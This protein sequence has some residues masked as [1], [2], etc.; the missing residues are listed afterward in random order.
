MKKNSSAAPTAKT[1]PHVKK[2]NSLVAIPAGQVQGRVRVDRIWRCPPQTLYQ[3][4]VGPHQKLH[5]VQSSVLRGQIQG[6][7]TPAVPDSRI[8][9]VLQEQRDDGSMTVLCGAM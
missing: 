7:L 8:A 9:G 1:A 6:R 4:R 5:G 2:I 3:A